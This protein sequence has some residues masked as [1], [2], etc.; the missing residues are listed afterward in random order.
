MAAGFLPEASAKMDMT[1]D[2]VTENH[3]NQQKAQH[4]FIVLSLHGSFASMVVVIILANQKIHSKMH[5]ISSMTVIN[6][7]SF[8]VGP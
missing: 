2:A 5:E 4:A 6:K 3:D 1:R 8:D 7:I